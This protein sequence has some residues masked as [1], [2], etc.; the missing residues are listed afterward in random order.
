VFHNIETSGFRDLEILHFNISAKKITP[1]R[2]QHH[3]IREIYKK[4]RNNNCL[5]CIGKTIITYLLMIWPLKRGFFYCKIYCR[6]GRNVFQVFHYETK[7]FVCWKMRFQAIMRGKFKTNTKQ[8]NRVF[9]IRL[10]RL[11]KH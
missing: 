5:I 7:R 9:H 10:K 3:F 6:A 8:R 1:S 11:K 2:N 4:K